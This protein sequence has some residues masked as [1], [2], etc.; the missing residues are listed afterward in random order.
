M[1][2]LALAS[3]ASLASGLAVDPA[4]RPSPLSVAIEVVGNSEV[5]ATVTNSGDS[6]LKLLKT[7]SILDPQAVEKTEIVGSGRLS[8]SSSLIFSSSPHQQHDTC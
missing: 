8:S 6:D 7:G 1:R 3:L 5:K 2:F 4:Q